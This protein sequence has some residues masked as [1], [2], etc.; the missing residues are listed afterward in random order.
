MLLKN[1]FFMINFW[2]M[3]VGNMKFWEVFFILKFI[4]RKYENLE[5]FVIL[6]LFYDLW[7]YIVINC[8]LEYMLD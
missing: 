2:F 7:G 4:L 8:V 3:K 5:W 6:C 1:G